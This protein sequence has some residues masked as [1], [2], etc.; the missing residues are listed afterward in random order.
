MATKAKTPTDEKFE[1]QD[2]DLFDALSAL[3]KKDYEY[4]TQ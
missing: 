2:I 4:V 3:D 1:K